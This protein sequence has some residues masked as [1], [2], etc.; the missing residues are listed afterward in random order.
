MRNKTIVAVTGITSRER[1]EFRNAA[2]APG[3]GIY[4][5]AIRGAGMLVW[6]A[7]VALAPMLLAQG[8]PHVTGVAPAS[9]KVNDTVAVAGENLGKGSVVAVYLSD[10]KT[11]FK[12]AVVDQAA[13]KVSIKVPQV[14]AGDYNVSIQVG[15]NIFIQPVRFQVKE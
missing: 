5:K 14:K 1:Q 7:A 4:R 6:M 2:A 11:D 15:G 8:S 13:D 12:A 9:G 10:D 3:L